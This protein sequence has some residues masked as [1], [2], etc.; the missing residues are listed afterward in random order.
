MTIED[1]KK[2]IRWA[3][4]G[5]PFLLKSKNKV[6]SVKIE[7]ASEPENPREYFDPIGTMFCWHPRYR[8]GD[9]QDRKS[10]V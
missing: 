9:W 5:E 6:I 3:N 1:I 4:I 2:E 10:V 8:L 7:R